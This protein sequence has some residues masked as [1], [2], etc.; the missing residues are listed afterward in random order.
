MV[1]TADDAA[2]GVTQELK[3][4][5]V[6]ATSSRQSEPGSE[7]AYVD[8]CRPLLPRGNNGLLTSASTRVFPGA[9][10]ADELGLGGW[11]HELA[12]RWSICSLPDRIQRGLTGPQDSSDCHHRSPAP[13]YCECDGHT[14]VPHNNPFILTQIPPS[15]GKY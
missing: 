11:F 12:G 5:T 10:F 9:K 4:T 13:F 15:G 2:K 1:V 7:P 6:D 3:T 8:I 14:P